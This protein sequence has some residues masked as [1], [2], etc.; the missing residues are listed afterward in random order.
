ML[1]HVI[2]CAQDT[3]TLLH[4][5]PV[6][7][8]LPRPDISSLLYPRSSQAECDAFAAR[9]CTPDRCRATLAAQRG[10][11]HDP[12]ITTRL[13]PPGPGPPWFFRQV[14]GPRHLV[15]HSTGARQQVC[16]LTMFPRVSTLVACAL[17]MFSSFLCARLL[18]QLSPPA[19]TPISSILPPS[20]LLPLLL[21]PSL[22]LHLQGMWTFGAMWKP[23]PTPTGSPRC[24]CSL[25]PSSTARASPAMSALLHSLRATRNP[26]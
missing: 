20:A 11:R 15:T 3:S 22:H 25:S 18:R 6:L 1:P 14:S 9:A 12:C 5:L 24:N 8:A 13:H 17:L 21:P 23:M 10:I 16:V 26:K 2:R 4:P 19:S 7:T